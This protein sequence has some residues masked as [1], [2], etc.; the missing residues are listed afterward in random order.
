MPKNAPAFSI[1]DVMPDYRFLCQRPQLAAQQERR[2]A[3]VISDLQ[4]CPRSTGNTGFE[5]E[6]HIP[7]PI[8]LAALDNFKRLEALKGRIWSVEPGGNRMWIHEFG[9]PGLKAFGFPHATQAR[10]IGLAAALP[11]CDAPLRE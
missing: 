5:V 10:F 8:D 1:S 9:E 6:D 11:I 2:G 4:A 3:P 7:E